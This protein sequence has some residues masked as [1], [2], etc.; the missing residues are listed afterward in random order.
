MRAVRPGRDETRRDETRQ[1]AV[2]EGG[3]ASVARAGLILTM[4]ECSQPCAAD[5]RARS[6]LRQ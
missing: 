1:K 5:D 2:N 3:R 6:R 4:A